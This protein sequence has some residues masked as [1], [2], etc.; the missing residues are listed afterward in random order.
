MRLE[1]EAVYP[2]VPK[3]P[4]LV[5]VPRPYEEVAPYTKP[6]EVAFEPPVEVMVDEAVTEVWAMT[7]VL[8]ERT[9]GAHGEVVKERIAPVEVPAEFTVYARS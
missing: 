8:G 5:E 4:E 6:S 1:I 3:E 2:P 9:V 7:V